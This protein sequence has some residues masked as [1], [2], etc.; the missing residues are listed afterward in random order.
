MN[1]GKSRVM[2]GNSGGVMKL[3]MDLVYLN[4]YFRSNFIVI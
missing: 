3:V 4:I 1:A 2:V